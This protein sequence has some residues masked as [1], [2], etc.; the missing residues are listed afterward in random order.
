MK[1]KLTSGAAGTPALTVRRAAMTLLLMLLTATTAWADSWTE[2]GG[3]G[4]SGTVNDPYYVNMQGTKSITIPSGITTFKVYDN[5]GK[6]G[7]FTISS[8]DQLTLT[9]PSGYILHIAGDVVTSTRR[10]GLIVYEGTTTGGTQIASVVSAGTT[11]IGCNTE[12]Q[13]AT[14]TFSAPDRTTAAAGYD[15]TVTV[16]KPAEYFPINIGQVTGGTVTASVGGEGVTSACGDQTVTLTA[17]PANGYL[18]S[19]I[20]ATDEAGNS[21]AITDM[22]WYTGTNTATFTMPVSAVSIVPTFTNIWTA[23]GGLY[24]NMPA[25]G[26]R[27]ITLPTGMQS[28]KVYDDG[29]KYGNYSNNCSGTLTLTAPSGF[30][31]HLSGTTK[32]NNGDYLTVY[33]GDDIHGTE[34]ASK[35]SGQ[36]EIQT[37]SSSGESMTLY[38]YSN[39][40]FTN[41]G[42]DLTVSVA[43]TNAAYAIGIDNPAAGGTVTASVGGVGVTS[44]CGGQ[45]VTLTASPANGYLLSDI[46]AT[47]EVGHSVAITDMRWYTGTNTATF[48]M[49]FS[50]VSIVPTFTNIW[51]ADGGLY[52][53]MPATGSRTLTLPTGM[54][55]LKVYDNGGRYGNYSNNCSG[56]LTLTAPSGFVL[57]LLGTISTS[58]LT[59][60]D[61][62]YLTV[63][64]GDDTNGTELASKLHS[65]QSEIQAVS[66]SGESM[67]LYFH[68]NGS[69]T[70]AG[71]D[72]TVR[73][74]DPN[75]LLNTITVNNP[76]T[77][78]TI[79]TSVDG[80][81]AA[82]AREG[83]TVTLTATPASGYLLSDISATDELG[84][85]VAI[86]D[87]R[88]YTGTNT[89]TFTMPNTA[90]TVTPTFTNDWTAD[91]GLY[92][93]MP[94]LDSKAVT[95]P[96][97]VQSFKVYDDGGKYDDYAV[98]SNSTDDYAVGSNSTLTLTAP[99]GYVL[100]LSG[101]ID[102]HI[103]DFL[104]VYDNGEASGMQLLRTSGKTDIHTVISSGNAMTL[105]FHMVNLF[106]A[107]GYGFDL[108]VRVVDPITQSKYSITL[109][110]PD[111]GGTVTASVG[112]VS[113]TS[114]SV[115]QPVTLTAMPA[116][117]YRLS[118][119][120]VTDADN[121]SV[122]TTYA[123][124]SNTATF[125]MPNADVTVT[126]TFT[127]N[128]T[129]DDEFY[130]NMPATGSLV[131]TI[132]TCVQSFKVYDDGGK[133]G[134]YSNI[135]SG[136]L[137]L[138]APAGCVLQLSGS[139]TTFRVDQL[140]V[141]DNGAASGTKLIDAVS[142][143][144]DNNPDHIIT[145]PIPTVTSSGNAMTLYFYAMNSSNSSGLDLTVTILRV[146]SLA[147]AD[148]NSTVISNNH[149]Y[150]ADVTL[151]GRTLYK[152]GAWNTLCLPFSLTAEQIAA[153]ADFAGATLME[154]GNSTGCNTGF[155]AKTGTLT[156]DFVDAHSINAG[157]AYIVKWTTTGDPIDS[158]VFHAVT[159]QN[160]DPADQSA[161]S[162]DGSVTFKGTYDA[163]TFT[164]TDRSVLFLGSNN[165]LY[166]PQPDFSD[167][168]HP[169][170]PSVGAFRAY[171]QLNGIEA[172]DPAN[173]VRAFRL[174]FGDSEG[175]SQGIKEIEDGRLKIENEAGAWYTLDGVHLDGKPTKKGLY[176]HGVRK[177]V[178]P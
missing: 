125:R 131:A 98:G 162:R 148:D 102:T 15:L 110:N 34:L 100:E 36:S 85:S 170:Y 3:T 128:W 144:P 109:N 9:A 134:N 165:T 56:S 79:A 8:N 13:S 106:H 76:N 175:E 4:G 48:T 72:L 117:G 111:T 87:M 52:I 120:S 153:H 58:T 67:T 172:G 167:P 173:G 63:Y 60:Y 124:Y 126:P 35:G 146:I 53:N 54:Q 6:N 178:I 156:L 158:P 59:D 69:Y 14:I 18:L 151:Q 27:T 75:A 96:T 44:A 46:S 168:A 91:G 127:D 164:D 77:G 103:D 161:T 12:G 78:G 43:E 177:V 80:V 122:A 160:E 135:C 166:Y 90:V 68:S 83:H 66:S 112:G 17:T 81:G 21:V 2:A 19:D 108:T 50:A 25:T 40:E 41:P 89:A 11:T 5:G 92:I 138:T 57:Q 39:S 24:I 141:Y 140:T 28:L 73:V 107:T 123:W 139:I 74:V 32:I 7:D 29:G 26:S 121:N 95:I 133:D 61:D 33:D 154:L 143:S 174:N 119:I 155:D 169:V 93:N 10:Q 22:R 145:I 116:N 132:P 137:V 99:A 88:W 163:I 149:G 86:T 171:F 129:A 45:T 105:D 47:D 101:S 157:H 147:D 115:G 118:G 130:I 42:V 23:D 84:N 150:I 104:T 62:D 70:R 65:V 16:Y 1:T 176:I 94:A 113:A 142:S 38:L 64:D 136:T 31:L 152:D 114:A 30:V 51:T 82:S 37:V 159:I 71:L 49:P 97:G 55:S 20:S